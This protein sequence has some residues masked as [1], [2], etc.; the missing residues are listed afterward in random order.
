MQ[1]PWRWRK[2]RGR[3]IGRPPKSRIIFTPPQNIMFIP[4][5]NGT[6]I[7][8]PPVVLLLDE[9]EAFRLVYYEG[10]TQEEAANRMG[11]SRGTLWRLLA[12]ARK[13][14]AQALTEKRPIII[15]TTPPT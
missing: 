2:R 10:L 15:T 11:V 13:K 1:R 3:R 8:A 9:F 12:N 4:S 7:S 6:P 14:I 5:V